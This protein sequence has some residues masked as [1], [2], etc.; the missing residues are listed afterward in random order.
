MEFLTQITTTVPPGAEEEFERR[1][2]AEAARARELHASGHLVRLW[3]PVGEKRSIGLWRA[4]D[5][6][7]LE[8]EVLKTLPLRDWMTITVTPLEP[9]P[10]DPARSR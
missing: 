5:A 8:A 6:A 9:H 4:D 10:N 1:F 2:R 7:A 3:R